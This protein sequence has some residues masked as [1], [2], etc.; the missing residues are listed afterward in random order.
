MTGAPVPGEM[1]L[2]TNTSSSKVLGQ[3]QNWEAQGVWDLLET[4]ENFAK[5]RT[6]GPGLK[7]Q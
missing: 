6:F 1:E 4:K 7:H 5:E 2:N 3:V